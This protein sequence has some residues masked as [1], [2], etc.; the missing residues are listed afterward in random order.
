MQEH[1][2]VRPNVHWPCSRNKRNRMST[3]PCG[4]INN[5]VGKHL[6]EL[7]QQHFDFESE[8]LGVNSSFRHIKMQVFFS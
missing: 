6:S 2:P 4:R 3:C 8:L 5:L 1:I 7:L